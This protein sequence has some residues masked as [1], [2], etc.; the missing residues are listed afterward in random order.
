V[1]T[2]VNETLDNLGGTAYLLVIGRL[3]GSERNTEMTTNQTIRTIGGAIDGKVFVTEYRPDGSTSAGWVA[4]EQ[5][6][7]WHGESLHTGE[8]GECA[9]PTAIFGDGIFQPYACGCEGFRYPDS[10]D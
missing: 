4:D 10:D 9:A 5:C 7:C 8:D 2:F 6:R 3:A 1:V